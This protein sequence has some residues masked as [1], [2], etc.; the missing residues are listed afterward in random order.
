MPERPLD[1][2]AETERGPLAWP[3]PADTAEV[4]LEKM[5]ERFARLGDESE[6]ALRT[7]LD[8]LAGSG[9]HAL[10]KAERAAFVEKLRRLLNKSDRRLVCPLCREPSLP[11]FLAHTAE[12][13]LQLQH[14]HA[15]Q[16]AHVIYGKRSGYESFPTLTFVQAETTAE[17]N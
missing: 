8:S 6:S 3:Q 9:F 17:K 4:G 13:T 2:I 14:R 11:Y 12:G 10:P 1:P 5:L 7:A 15:E 16:V